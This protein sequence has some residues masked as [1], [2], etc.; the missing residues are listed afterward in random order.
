MMASHILPRGLWWI[1]AKTPSRRLH[2]AFGLRLVL[3]K[4]S[5]QLLRLRWHGFLLGWN[6]AMDVSWPRDLADSRPLRALREVGAVLGK[7]FSHVLTSGDTGDQ[8]GSVSQ[9]VRQ[10]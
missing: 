3:L 1:S 6:S 7:L 8:I 2:L 9:I 10:L 5:L 4:C